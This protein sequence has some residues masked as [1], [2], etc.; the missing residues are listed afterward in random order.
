MKRLLFF[1]IFLVSLSVSAMP[2][3]KLFTLKTPDKNAY[4]EWLKGSG[5]KVGNAIKASSIGVCFPDAGAPELDTVYLFRMAESM[6]NLLDVDPSNPV[7]A[8]EFSKA[9]FEWEIK[10]ADYWDW[11]IK[12]EK[13]PLG[14]E[15]AAWNVAIKTD[16]IPAY[17]SFA[18]SV[19]DGY[20]NNDFD[21][22]GISVWRGR[23]GEFTGLLMI[24]LLAPDKAGLGAML[25]EQQEVWFQDLISQI[26]SK[27]Q[28]VQGFMLMCHNVF[29]KTQN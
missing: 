29:D 14:E 10:T 1:M 24:S 3:M 21:D 16:D 19:R 25:D 7:I 5:P 28:P 9:N 2:G 22:V 12:P 18:E 6:T 13:W 8:E 23:T 11:L 26:A 27:R 4:L 20:K 17:L 15:W